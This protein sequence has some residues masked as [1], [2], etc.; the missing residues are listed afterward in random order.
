MFLLKMLIARS[1]VYCSVCQRLPKRVPSSIF[2][3]QV[4]PFVGYQQVA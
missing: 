2:E 1:H 4:T 3:V